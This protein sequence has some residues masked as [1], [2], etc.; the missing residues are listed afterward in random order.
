[1]N[2]W[3][4]SH[5]ISRVRICSDKLPH[6]A[7][8]RTW[9]WTVSQKNT[10]LLSLITIPT[11]RPKSWLNWQHAIFLPPFLMFTNSNSVYMILQW[12]TKLYVTYTIF[13]NVITHGCCSKMHTTS[14]PKS[15]VT[16][17]RSCTIPSYHSNLWF[18]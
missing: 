13:L 10:S 6:V 11:L 12:L 9:H 17:L 5:M 1:M 14:Y 18:F 16:M 7:N 2:E 3:N 8:L 15:A 4:D